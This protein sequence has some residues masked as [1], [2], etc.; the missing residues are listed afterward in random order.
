MGVSGHGLRVLLPFVGDG[1]RSPIEP[2]AAF[3]LAHGTAVIAAP[4]FACRIK[5]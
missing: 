3:L 4:S 1:G 5:G 2:S